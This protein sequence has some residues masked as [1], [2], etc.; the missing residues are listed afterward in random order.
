MVKDCV[1]DAPML[2][3]AIEWDSMPLDNDGKGVLFGSQLASNAIMHVHPMIEPLII[4]NTHRVFIPHLFPFLMG[5]NH[6]NNGVRHHLLSGLLL[7][8][9]KP[10]KN[11]V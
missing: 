2:K 6:G 5:L 7:A 4:P 9:T 3:V 10:R 8:N 1:A 11:T